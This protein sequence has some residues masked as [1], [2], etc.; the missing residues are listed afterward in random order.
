[1]MK[2]LTMNWFSEGTID[3]EYKQYIL[4]AYLD[5]VKSFYSSHKIY[6]ALSDLITQYRN[7][8][9]FKETKHTLYEQ[10]P[11]KLTKIDLKNTALHFEKE[12][13]DDATMQEIEDIVDFA[14]PR[15]QNCVEEGREIYELV[16]VKLIINPIGVIPIYK[17]EGY[18]LLKV[19]NEPVI[20]TFRFEISII[21]DAYEKLNAIHTQFVG[22]YELGITTTFEHIKIDLIKTNQTLP[23]PA[24][25][26]V[27][28][29]LVVPINETL[30]PI[31]KRR[32]LR[33]FYSP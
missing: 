16:D 2:T 26:S 6:P 32:L 29:K 8:Q 23:N 18:I 1:M 25:Y 9:A 13:V 11:K 7:L 30:L 5:E 31:T 20:H 3:F 33:N 28:S 19:G 17:N 10:F 24:T 14:I 4:L 21:Q 12:I 22:Y 15:I 27:E